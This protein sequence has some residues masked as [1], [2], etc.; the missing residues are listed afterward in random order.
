MLSQNPKYSVIVPARNG[1]KYLP[2]CVESIIGQDFDDYE[3]ILS[4]DHSTDETF[5]YIES[6]NHPNIKKVTPPQGLSMAEHWGWAMDQSIGDWLIFVGQDDGLQPYFFR[7]AEI[8][9]KEADRKKLRTIMSKRA[10]FFWP[11]CDALYGNTAISFNA[12]NEIKILNSKFQS[13]RAL[14]GIQTYFELP[15]MYTTSIFSRKI[16]DEVKSIQNGKVFLAHPQDA[17]LA[18]IACSL[19][20]HY[21]KCMIP[22]GW[23]GSSPKSAGLAVMSTTGSKINPDA[24]ADLI[25]VK[26][27]YLNKTTKSAI[28][29]NPLAGDFSLGSFPIYFWGAL[30]QTEILRSFWINKFLKSNLF[31]SLMFSSVMYEIES[32]I[33]FNVGKRM[34]YFFELIKI[35]NCD[36]HRI[37]I[38]KNNIFPNIK[39]LDRYFSILL[40]F[41]IRIKNRFGFKK[42]KSISLYKNWE[43]DKNISMNSASQVVDALMKDNNM[44]ELVKRY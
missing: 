29:N 14:L 25:A 24:E 39:R 16:I 5:K 13:L 19:D 28:K 41:P 12:I 32:S 8:L 38:F 42:V 44:L 30:L 18:A 23:V 3:L 35:N 1:V 2:T 27:D 20:S 26:A 21:L 22:L 15:E 4:D 33:N 6:L 40:D 17:N 7:L 11:G 36:L 43:E 31:K 9:T 10:Y 34:V 37:I